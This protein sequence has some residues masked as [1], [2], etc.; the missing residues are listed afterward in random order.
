MRHC[1]PTNAPR[2]GSALA[3][4]LAAFVFA[5][6]SGGTASAQGLTEA[7]LRVRF[8]L[9][10]T[11]FTEWPEKTFPSASAPLNLC[12]LGFG[13]PF[14]GALNDLQG[15][16][17]GG[18]KIVVHTSI[19]PEQAGDC[20][21]LYVPDGE[22]RRVSI[23]REVIAKQ[24]VLIVGESEGVFERG[25]MIALRMVDRHLTF[26]VKLSAA[27]KVVINFS[28]QMLHAAEEVLP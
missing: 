26:V 7:Q 5:L 3:A 12:V 2:W 17:A 8:L 18:R 14:E 21:V 25:G 27:R 16:V 9:N 20:N 23:A 6:P 10:F 13:D 15:A 28:P 19:A 1:L 11:R 24:A 22:L 4:V